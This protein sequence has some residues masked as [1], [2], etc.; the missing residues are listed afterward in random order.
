[1]SHPFYKWWR[2]QKLTSSC[3]DKLYF[4]ITELLFSYWLWRHIVLSRY[5]IF[6][7]GFWKLYLCLWQK[8][9]GPGL[10]LSQNLYFPCLMCKIFRDFLSFLWIKQWLTWVFPPLNFKEHTTRTD[11]STSPCS[12]CTFSDNTTYLATSGR[13]Q[14]LITV[15][16]IVPLQLFFFNFILLYIQAEENMDRRPKLRKWDGED[17]DSDPDEGG[18]A[19]SKFPNVTAHMR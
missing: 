18:K 16:V 9:G 4:I 13:G 15:A 7:M 11:F 14:Y 8:P 3:I 1:M 5:K 12:R 19:N 17:Y 10:N 2:F 6:P